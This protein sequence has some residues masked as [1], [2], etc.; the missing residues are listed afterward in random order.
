MHSKATYRTCFNDS[1]GNREDRY[2][3]DCRGVVIVFIQG[4]QD[5]TC[6]LKDVERMKSLHSVS[7]FA[8]RVWEETHFIEKE[9]RYGLLLDLDHV[10]AK[11][12]LSW[13][14]LFGIQT[15]A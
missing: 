15:L 2:Q 13:L 1:A 4:P 6:D 14:P 8:M 11:D 7:V 10:L 5:E 9:L 3:E 12:L